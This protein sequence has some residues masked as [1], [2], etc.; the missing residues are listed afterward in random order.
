MRCLKK[1]TS[2]LGEMEKMYFYV[3]NSF[4]SVMVSVLLKAVTQ[5]LADEARGAQRR[6]MH[7]ALLKYC[8]FL[9]DILSF[10]L[11]LPIVAK[12]NCHAG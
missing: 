9:T 12:G 1:K 4:L 11:R 8:L 2:E 6:D 7:K 10:A 5:P 3:I